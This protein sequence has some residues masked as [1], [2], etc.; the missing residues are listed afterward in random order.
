MSLNRLGFAVL[1]SGS[2]ACSGSSEGDTPPPS[3]SSTHR[4]QLLSSVVDS[5][6]VPSFIAFVAAADELRDAAAAWAASPSDTVARDSARSAFRNASIALQ[7]LEPMQ[8]GPA[9]AP[10]ETT[11]G[12]GIRGELYSWPVVSP[13]RVDQETVKAEFGSDSFFTSRLANV[14]GLDALEYLMF[15]EAEAN[16]CPASQTINATGTWRVLVE[17]GN[18]AEARA[19]YASA[20]AAQ[21]AKDA[22]RLREAW[23]QGFANDL[24]TAGQTGSSFASTQAALDEIFAAIF[25]LERNVKDT[26]LAAPLGI[27]AACMNT[28]CPDIVESQHAQMSLEWVQANLQGF[29]L[30]FLG[31]E[32]AE[33][34][35]GFD[36]LLTDEGFEELATTMRAQLETAL[37]ASQTASAPMREQLET[38]EMMT[39]HSRVNDLARNLKTQFVSALGVRV[40]NEGAA[41]ND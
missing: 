11:G 8:I 26:K 38:T 34:G 39:L 7:R 41:D 28:S 17:S 27:T 2:I 1:V 16:A 12:A 25:Y 9:G 21:L 40:P 20:V 3:G 30:V 24:K 36:D 29:A 13:C 5:A 33:S 14:Y 6:L 32:T 18:L 31:G 35:Y 37:S 19:S 10:N 23:T 4:S 15:T 22:A